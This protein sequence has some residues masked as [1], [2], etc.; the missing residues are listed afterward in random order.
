[1]SKEQELKQELKEMCEIPFGLYGITADK[2]SKGRDNIFVVS[3]MI[4]AG[5]KIIQYREKEIGRAHV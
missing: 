4:K 3:E 1:M 2:F 5:I